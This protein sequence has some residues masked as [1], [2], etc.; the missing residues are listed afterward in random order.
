V[1]D[2]QDNE[3]HGLVGWVLGIAVTLAVVTA[4]TTGIVGVTGSA[5]PATASATA[6]APASGLPAAVVARVFFAS[7]VAVLPADAAAALAPLVE[8][9]RAAGSRKVVVSGYH[10]STGSPEV[11]AELAR[12]RA[13]AV[14]VALVAVGI[15]A[16]RIELR[17]PVM[18]DAGDERAARR[19]EATL[20]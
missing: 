9:A 14:S 15:P 20:E 16:E 7:G 1:Q 10:D 13:V 18:T 4:L 3:H 11:N 6:S 19:V 5:P 17:K 8:A 12:Q 2:E